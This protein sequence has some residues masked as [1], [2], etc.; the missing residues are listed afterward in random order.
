M[1][2]EIIIYIQLYSF[3]KNAVEFCTL[4]QAYS[5]HCSFSDSSPL[6][7]IAVQTQVWGSLFSKA[8]I[9]YKVK[10]KHTMLKRK[11]TIQKYKTAQKPNIHGHSLQVLLTATEGQVHPQSTL[12]LQREETE[13]QQNQW[14]Y[15]E[16][17]KILGSGALPSFTYSL[18]TLSQ[19]THM[20]GAVC[21]VSPFQLIHGQ[22]STG[23]HLISAG[24]TILHSSGGCSICLHLL[25]RCLWRAFNFCHSFLAQVIMIS[26]CYCRSSMICCA[27]CA[28][29][30]WLWNDFQ[31]VWSWLVV[32]L[33]M[34]N[35]G[36]VPQEKF[37][38]FLQH[39][40][41]LADWT[42]REFKHITE[43]RG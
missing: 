27:T 41:T 3:Q 35:F 21:F 13:H 38:W 19:S 15:V 36:I 9:S 24:F 6:K 40:S 33:F 16:T 39:S 43:Q 14:E 25:L 31:S 30:H 29:P 37:T 23:E 32:L 2:S 26:D 1:S 7:V 20:A 10:L 42:G 22:F 12:I 11:R 34:F 4:F 17:K 8:R 5:H 18:N 28:G